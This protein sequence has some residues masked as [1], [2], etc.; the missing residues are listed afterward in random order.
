MKIAFFGDIVG[1]TGRKKLEAS[2]QQYV[3]DEKIDFV[4]ANAE[5]AT[6]GAGLSATHAADLLKMSVD[7][8]TLGD[9]AYDNKELIPFLGHTE[10]VVR[11]INYSDDCPG[12][13][14]QIF[15]VH[16][17]KILVV[18]VL[19]RVFMKK[20]FLDPFPFLENI[21]FEYKL[22]LNIDCI[23]V[24]VH[25]EAT[26]EK[27]AIGHFCDG[28][29]S[30]VIG[31]HTHVPTGDARILDKGTAY[32]SDA[33]MSG[34]YNSIIG[35]DKAE[36]MRRFLTNQISGRFTPAEGEATLCGV[37]VELNDNGKANKIKVIRIGGVLG[38][39]E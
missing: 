38:C 20:K 12:Q 16:N 3:S 5:N 18:Q 14:L 31:T 37:S 25:A 4:V 33:G 27:M 10:R 39:L 7:C 11:P 2:L 8:I 26:S 17:K 22:G 32:Q 21:F 1:K 34:D 9:H 36:P 29:A 13:G 23:I 6:A 19:G 30:L 35:M 28:K 15:S 24:D